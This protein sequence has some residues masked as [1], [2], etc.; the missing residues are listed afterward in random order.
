MRDAARQF[1]MVLVDDPDR[2]VVHLLRAA[3]R[4]RDDG[5]RERV[6]D[7]PQQHVIAQEA[8]QLLGAEPEDVGEA[9]ASLAL[10]LAQQQ[11]AQ[12]VKDRDEQ[13]REQRCSV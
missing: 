9:A 1:G 12:Q 11:Q 3:L 6:D 10:L 13:R 4:L 2:G 8:A 5:E 7:E